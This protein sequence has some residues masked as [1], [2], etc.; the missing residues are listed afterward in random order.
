MEQEKSPGL[1]G[2]AVVQLV[3]DPIQSLP[4]QTICHRFNVKLQETTIESPFRT[5][6]ASGGGSTS[7]QPITAHAS[8]QQ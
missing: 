6:Q 2:C 3:K 1:C 5:S 7:G 4:L 8:H